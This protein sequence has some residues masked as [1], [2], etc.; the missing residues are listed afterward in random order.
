MVGE[1]L[2]G[3]SAFSALVG[4][5]RGLKDMNDA[6]VR[7]E[8]VYALTEKLLDAQ[9]QYTTLAQKVSELETQLAAYETWEREKERYELKPHGHRG[10]LAYALKEGVEPSEPAHSIC[11]DCYQQRKK[12]IV[13]NVHHVVGFAESLE[14][15]VC[16]WEAYTKGH[17]RVE[18]VAPKPRRR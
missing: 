17:K 5:A 3:F 16:G 15:H 2:S 8:A 1:A 13:Q 14:C 9:Q 18:H 4:M 7:N 12:S 11:P 10:A 6:V